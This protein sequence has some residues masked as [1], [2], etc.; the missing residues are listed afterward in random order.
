MAEDQIRAQ[1]G[2]LATAHVSGPI[3][4]EIVHELGR[5]ARDSTQPR[6]P[7]SSTR[8]TVP[9]ATRPE[10]DQSLGPVCPW[11]EQ[12]QTNTNATSPAMTD[13]S[14]RA[15]DSAPS[16]PLS[17]RWVQASTESSSSYECPLCLEPVQ[18]PV[19]TSCGHVFCS[20]CISTAL[21]ISQRCPLCMEHVSIDKTIRIY[22]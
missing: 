15:V 20:H 14:L 11:G 9:L 4:W 17:C 18:A 6:L 10:P 2:Q 16:D 8:R 7:E 1:L 3:D 12:H 13:Q 22:I 5:R 21:R 19:A